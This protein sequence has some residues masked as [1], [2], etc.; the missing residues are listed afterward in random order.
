MAGKM[1]KAMSLLTLS[2]ILIVGLAANGGTNTQNGAHKEG[3][4]STGASFSPSFNGMKYSSGTSSRIV[5]E[6]LV[7]QNQSATI[8]N[9]LTG[10][11]HIDGPAGWM[12]QSF[13]TVVYNLFENR[14]YL[15]NSDFSSGSSSP[16][17]WSWVRTTTEF[18]PTYD[19]LNNWVYIWAHAS[20]SYNPGD[21]ANWTQ[22]VYVDRSSV[23]GAQLQFKIWKSGTIEDRLN[24]T[25]FVNKKTLWTRTHDLL[26]NSAQ[27]ISV[28]LTAVQLPSFPGNLVVTL[29]LSNPSGQRVRT[30]NKDVYFDDVYLYIKCKPYPESADL[31]IKLG[32]SSYPLVGYGYGNGRASLGLSTSPPYD[33]TFISNSTGVSLKCNSTA[34]LFHRFLNTSTTFGASAGSQVNYNV[35]KLSFLDAADKIIGT[36]KY[37]RDALNVSFPRDWSYSS[38]LLPNENTYNNIT[39]QVR[40]YNNNSCSWIIMVN[41]TGIGSYRPNPYVIVSQ[42][43][44]YLGSISTY[45]SNATGWVAGNFFVNGSRIKVNSTVQPGGASKGSAYVVFYNASDYSVR[46]NMSNYAAT[47]ASNRSVSFNFKWSDN[48]SGVGA[49]VSKSDLITLV[50]WSNGSE[51]GV[52]WTQISFDLTPPNIKITAPGGI[53]YLRGIPSL[54]ISEL[55][56]HPKNM[57]LYVNGTNVGNW[58][59]PSIIYIFNTTKYGDGHVELKAQGWDEVDHVNTTILTVFV[60]NTQPSLATNLPANGSYVHQTVSLS[61]TSTDTNFR[62]VA[63]FIDGVNITSSAGAHSGNIA[64]NWD[65]GG[66]NKDTTN[67]TVVGLDLAGN[68]NKTTSLVHVDNTPP[69]L[70]LSLPTIGQY[71]GGNPT[72]NMLCTDAHLRNVTLLIDG[73]PMRTWTYGN[74]SYSWNTTI[75]SDGTHTLG[76]IGWDSAGN[77]NETALLT[78][79]VDNTPPSTPEL[80]YP[81]DDESF[82]STTLGLPLSWR[83]SLDSGSGVAYYILQLDTSPSFDSNNLRTISLNTTSYPIP[84]SQP[85]ANGTWYW[86]VYSVDSVGNVGSYS[87]ARS[88]QVIVKLVP[89]PEGLPLTILIG[90]LGGIPA[91]AILSSVILLRRRKA[92]AETGEYSTKSLM[93]AYIFSGDGRA[94][95]SH[96]FKETKVEPQL[97]SGFLT[98]ISE[99]MK[100]VVGG[101]RRP[102]RTIERSDAKIII[103]FG[104]TVTGALVAKEASREYRRRLRAFVARFEDDYADKIPKWD[105]D[106]AFFQAAPEIIEEV[107]AAGAKVATYPTIA[108]LEDLLVS[109]KLSGVVVSV[110]GKTG[111][112]KTE[113]CLRYAASLLK[114]EKPVIVLAATLSPKEVRE[115]LKSNS[116]DVGKVEKQGILKVYDAYSGVSGLQSD[117]QYKFGS[118]G[119]LNNIN[120]AL[121]RHLGNLKNATIFFDSL[122]TMI[123][124][125]DLEL[126]VDFIRTV[127][128]KLQQGGYTAFFIVDSNAHDENTLNYILHV[129]DGEIETASETKK[130]GEIERLVSF[131]RLKGFKIKPGYHEFK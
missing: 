43:P 45:R 82:N 6:Y 103:E 21:N 26:Q 79:Y 5:D 61:I 127:K 90:L 52:N 71:V 36:T 17:Y 107:F 77:V 101:D 14:S 118:P 131:K 18:L 76:L 72:L 15:R 64:F 22:T 119:E 25:V 42:A 63:L 85:L 109:E 106:Q 121:S 4:G 87:S 55:D 65:T 40:K 37:Y 56:A 47:P 112:G 32:A 83:A 125:S 99:M 34:S 86:H 126:A 35:S 111:S 108:G 7:G 50:L 8:K 69:A 38:T 46:Y 122:S 93:A 104:T 100:E 67:L 102:L 98:A 51:V 75:Y 54:G 96:A 49:N 123:D 66:I 48:V 23:Q 115:Q 94:M 105:G 73:I 84:E 89:P 117:E 120:L 2:V 12:G 130:K 33:F 39:G 68:L 74:P 16:D 31:K 19:S 57:T 113:F 20:N 9:I 91:L 97:V 129:M 13:S 30:D 60:D 58:T 11:L 59:S 10:T 78:V 95:F 29:E 24:A 110:A 70:R 53:I 116:V 62:R 3:T 27:T 92:R 114:R 28:N 124:Y 1:A 81:N 128:V 41:V 44:N 80:T 88:F